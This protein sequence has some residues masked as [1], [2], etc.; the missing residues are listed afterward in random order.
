MR[1]MNST[2]G[3]KLRPKFFVIAKKLSLDKEKLF[4]KER[5]LVFISI[6]MSKSLCKFFS[7]YMIYIFKKLLF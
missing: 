3:Y 2:G 4:E 7:F 6:L 5:T 1:F